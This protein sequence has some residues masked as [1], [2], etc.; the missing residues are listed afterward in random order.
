MRGYESR[1]YCQG[2]VQA[3]TGLHLSARLGL[4]LLSR[5]LLEADS[6]ESLIDVN[7]KDIYGRTP[8]HEA[9]SNGHA[10]VVQ[11]LL[12]K[13]ADVESKDNVYRTPLLHAAKNG[14]ETT[15]KLL[16][17]TNGVNVDSLDYYN[18]IPL[19]FAARI[20]HRDVLALLISLSQGLNI[21][22]DFGRSP[23]WWA[24][25]TE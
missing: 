9:S 25:S 4:V 21:K 24:R 18:S 14:K 12:E 10:E 15:L 20:G 6:K 8:L 1:G 23:L 5:M 19:S 17:A 7:F 16:L 13:G 22:D 2:F 3:T 11:L